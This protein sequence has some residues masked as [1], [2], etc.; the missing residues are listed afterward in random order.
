M[1]PNLPYVDIRACYALYQGGACIFV[2]KPDC[3]TNDFVCTYASPSIVTK[4]NRDIAVILGNAITWVTFSSHADMV[5]EIICNQIVQAY[6]LLPEKLPDG[7]NLMERKT[8]IIPGDVN[9]F[10]LAEIGA[11]VDNQNAPG[12]PGY[13]G[14]GFAGLQNLVTIFTT[15][16]NDV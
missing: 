6:N 10:R 15:Q 12:A 11:A 16:H 7:E 14:V 13:T 8:I 9:T 1:D 5:P 3:L 4:Y 2:Q